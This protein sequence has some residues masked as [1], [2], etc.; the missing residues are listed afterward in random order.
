MNSVERKDGRYLRRKAMRDIHAAQ[1]DKSFDQIFNIKNLVYAG[2]ECCKGVRWKA[3]I[4]T[5]EANLVV[6]AVKAL[7]MIQEKA[8]VFRGFHSF[9]TIEHGKKRDIDAPNIDDR[10]L[11]KNICR[12]FLTKLYSRTFVKTNSASLVG[13]GMHFALNEFK[14]HLRD[15]YRKYGLTGYVYQYDF[16]SYFASIPH[17]KLKERARKYIK[18]DDVYELL[19]SFIDDFRLLKNQDPDNPNKGVGLG[20]EVSQLLA[21]DHASPI[22]HF[23]KD[24]CSIHGYG[25]YNDDGY[26]ICRSMEEVYRVQEG[27]EKIA[28]SLGIMM[29][30]KKCKI[31]PIKNRCFTFLKIRFSLTHTGKVVTKISKK[32]IKNMRRKIKKFRSLVDKGKITAE[33]VFVSYQS[34]RGYAKKFDS[35]KTVAAMDLFFVKRFFLELYNYRIPFKC[36]LGV[37]HTET[38]HWI[39][40]DRETK[41]IIMPEG[42]E[43]PEILHV[44]IIEEDED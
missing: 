36:H 12:R 24:Q 20:S 23:V 10:M 33:D 28:D 29:S 27:I 41:K 22:D 18:D 42:M 31:T 21:L 6:R 38:D 8:R 39:Y 32:S 25:R 7:K 14:K 37:I 35:Y 11:Q 16:K 43:I 34:W 30:K 40:Y 1:Y 4:I 13:K 9:S 3:S 26:C 44:N 2:R 5:F 17:D 19:C 15:H